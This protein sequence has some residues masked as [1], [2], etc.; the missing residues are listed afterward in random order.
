MKSDPGP[1]ATLGVWCR[2]CR[3]Q[4][5]P[6]PAEMA[7]RCGAGMPVLDIVARC[8]PSARNGSGSGLSRHWRVTFADH[9]AEY[10][11]SRH[12]PT[13]VEADD[14]ASDFLVRLQEEINRP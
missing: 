6:D 5:E 9:H 7:A 4:V 10:Q 14:Y 2:A 3:H 12:F 1:P 11:S 13:K 8:R